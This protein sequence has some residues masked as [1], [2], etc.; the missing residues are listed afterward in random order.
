MTSPESRE[1]VLRT[2]ADCVDRMRAQVALC[3]QEWPELAAAAADYAR[4]ADRIASHAQGVGYRARPQ[5]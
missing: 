1:T 4:A 5:R 2:T 3:A